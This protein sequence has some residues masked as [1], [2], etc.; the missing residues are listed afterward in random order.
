MV[1]LTD[2]IISFD[3]SRSERNFGDHSEY[4]KDMTLHLNLKSSSVMSKDCL[5]HLKIENSEI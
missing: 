2:K 3:G 5:H 4:E 1:L